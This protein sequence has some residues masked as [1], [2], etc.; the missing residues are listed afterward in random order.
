MTEDQGR[1][2]FWCNHVQPLNWPGARWPAGGRQSWLGGRRTSM[3]VGGATGSSQ[4]F[5][6]KNLEKYGKKGNSHDK[7]WYMKVDCWENHPKTEF[8]MEKYENV[9]CNHCQWR[10]FLWETSQ[11]RGF[12]SKPCLT[13]WWKPRY[14]DDPWGIVP[15][16]NSW[17]EH[18]S[19]SSFLSINPSWIK[20]PSSLACLPFS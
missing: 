13:G 19:S 20:S 8:I 16:P 1:F 5:S 10:C 12:S 4:L 15:N 18:H 14:T 17:L 6:E 7:W 9:R 2:F 3:Q 11:N